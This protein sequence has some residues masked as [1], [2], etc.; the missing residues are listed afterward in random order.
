MAMRY[1]RIK[2][3]RKEGAGAA[4]KIV[5]GIFG[6]LLLLIALVLCFK[7]ADCLVHAK[8]A[9]GWTAMPASLTGWSA[10]DPARAGKGAWARYEYQVGGKKYQ[11]QSLAPWTVEGAWG[12]MDREQALATIV[13]A[14]SGSKPL[15]VWVDPSDPTR[16]AVGREIPAGLCALACLI[17]VVPC[18][19]ATMAVFSGIGE[20]LRRARW[21][22]A[23]SYMLGAWALFH[24]A[25]AWA[26][27][28]L[29]EPGS[30]GVGAGVALV[31]VAAIAPWGAWWMGR[32][33]AL[34][35]TARR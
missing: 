27:L 19:L 20:L 26:V 6:V 11:G 1:K 2:A 28:W 5:A 10:G 25:P 4:T 35:W 18:G 17:L 34:E 24:G 21:R 32:A 30:V 33:A 29:A 31:A 23:Q 8:I 9:K 12:R 13:A 22:K 7:L 14:E 16:S 3:A 15:L